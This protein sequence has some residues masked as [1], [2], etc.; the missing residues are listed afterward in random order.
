[1][2][3]HFY[4]LPCF[5][6]CDIETMCVELLPVLFLVVLAVCVSAAP[7]PLLDLGMFANPPAD[8]CLNNS[9]AI[10]CVPEFQNIA[11]GREVEAS[12]TCGLTPSRH[13]KVHQN[14]YDSQNCFVCDSRRQHP[15]SYLTDLNIQS[16]DTCWVSAPGTE[17]AYNVTL[18]L[19]LGKK[20]EVTYVNLKFCS[21]IPENMV[22]YKSKD[23]GKSWIPLQYYSSECQ[24]TFNIDPGSVVTKANEQAALCSQEY[25]KGDHNFGTRVAFSTL[26]D[27]PSSFQHDESP[28]IQDWVTATDIKISF[29]KLGGPSTMGHFPAEL[30]EDE[31]FYG[32]S[33]FAVGG[34]CKCNGHASRCVE[35]QEGRLACECRHNTE[36]DDCEKCKPFHL[37]RPWARATKT[38]AH[39]CVGKSSIVTTVKL[40]L[41]S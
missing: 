32:V 29:L 35:N 33:D 8:P 34:R 9:L 23:F 7:Q 39:E 24:Q 2:L 15:S 10:Q 28:V 1:V 38:D 18:T 12:S 20:F 27:R 17:R 31:M 26:K 21:R 19:P 3:R 14:D 41:L 36:G 30:A 4:V 37:D 25:S 11:F 13:C 16:N 40:A 22:F 5:I 6:S